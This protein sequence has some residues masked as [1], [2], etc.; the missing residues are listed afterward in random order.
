MD[1]DEDLGSQRFSKHHRGDRCESSWMG[2]RN[3]FR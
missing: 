2:R 3:A 1:H